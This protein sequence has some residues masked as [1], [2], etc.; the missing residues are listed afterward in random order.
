M[1]P[2][3]TVEVWNGNYVGM[4]QAWNWETVPMDESSGLCWGPVNAVLAFGPCC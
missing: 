2:G 3:Y 1:D 4:Q